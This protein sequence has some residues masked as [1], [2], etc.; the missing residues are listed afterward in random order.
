MSRGLLAVDIQ[1]DF[2]RPDGSLYVPGGLEVAQGTHDLIQSIPGQAYK[3]KY[4]TKDWHNPFGNNG[5]HF[6]D[7]PDFVDNW[8][9][10]CIA[11]SWGSDLAGNL[12]GLLFDDVFHKGWDVPAYSGFQAFS[13]SNGVT[14]LDAA[15]QVYGI[16]E[17][18]V[19]GI[20][21]THCVLATVLDA[22]DLGYIVRVLSELT[23]GVDIDGTGKAHLAALEQMKAAGA[24]II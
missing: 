14:S 2:A 4:A 13:A 8:P 3:K 22:L 21:S 23:V 16:S 9:G 10:H 1:N 17:I 15:F 24:I 18:D 11:N 20:A 19:V 5:G 6:H 12:D 7:T